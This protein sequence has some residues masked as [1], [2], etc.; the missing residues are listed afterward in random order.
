MEAFAVTDYETVQDLVNGVYQR[1][2]PV[3]LMDGPTEC[4]VVMSP[5]MLE[6]ILFDGSLLNSFPRE[7]ALI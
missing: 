5:A 4:L 6:R 7:G 1:S 3:I 2:E